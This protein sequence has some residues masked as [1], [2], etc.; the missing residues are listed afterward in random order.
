MSLLLG[1]GALAVASFLLLSLAVAGAAAL[2]TGRALAL[3]W[4]PFRLAIFYLVPLTAAERFLHFAL[5]QQVLWQP[6]PWI[7]D[8]AIGLAIAAL[9]YHHTRARQMVCQYGFLAATG[10]E[11]ADTGFSQ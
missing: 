9:A 5:F 11:E 6:V 4:Q 1:D 2:A 8:Y 3:T 7:V 10:S